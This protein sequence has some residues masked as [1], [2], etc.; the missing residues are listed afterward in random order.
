MQTSDNSKAFSHFSSV[1]NAEFWTDER[2]YIREI[3]NDANFPDFS[4]AIARVEVGVTTQ[5]HR[6]KG[7][8]ETYIVRQGIGL[9]EVD[10]KKFELVEG[11]TLYIPP[12]GAQR[13]SNKGKQDLEFFCHCIPRFTPETY[14]NLEPKN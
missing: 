1:P 6:L 14:I 5:L 10:G 11:S 2:C 12:G 8:A 13:I 7:I 4:L 3:L 9:A